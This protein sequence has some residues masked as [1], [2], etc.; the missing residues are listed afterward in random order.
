MFNGGPL[1]ATSAVHAQKVK[2]KVLSD[3]EKEARQEDQTKVEKDNDKVKHPF[4]WFWIDHEDYEK[5]NLTITLLR[6]KLPIYAT[7]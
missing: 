2:L 5:E 7:N 3:Q 6:N 1:E 4:K